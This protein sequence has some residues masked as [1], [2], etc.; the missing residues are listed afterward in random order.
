[1]VAPNQCKKC[2]V[3]DYSGNVVWSEDDCGGGIYNMEMRAKVEAYDRGC[4]YQVRCS[5]WKNEEDE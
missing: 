4:D 5:T 2:E 3:V 1:M